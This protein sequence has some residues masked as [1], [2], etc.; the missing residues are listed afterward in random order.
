MSFFARCKTQ[1]SAMDVCHYL[2]IIGSLLAK[3][4]EQVLEVGI[5]TAQLTAALVMGLRYNG[6]GVLTC[7][8][9]WSEWRGVEPAGIVA[10][11]ESG[12][13][14]VAPVS[15]RNFLS[16]CPDN[17]YDFVIS[18]GDH[19]NVDQWVDDYFRITRPNGFIY[20][21]D[22]N[23]NSMFPAISRVLERVQELGLPYYHFIKSTR[24]EERCERGLLLVVNEK[25]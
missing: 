10:L 9:N 23:N 3:K 2:Q 15:E 24:P 25:P 20:F 1:E 19:R 13:R 5:G 11:R 8:D 14:V 18:D 17:T 6:T 22:T 16:E 7:V 21:H 4:P 12:V